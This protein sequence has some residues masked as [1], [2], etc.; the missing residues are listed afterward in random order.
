MIRCASFNVTF[1]EVPSEVCL[2][3]S[4]S[5]CQGR[6]E[7]CHSPYLHHDIGFDLEQELPALLELYHEE[8]TCVC[9]LGEGNDPEALFRCIHL[10]HTSGFKTCLYSGRDLIEEIPLIKKILPLLDYLKVGSYR[11]DLGGLCSRG[12][13][14]QFYAID[15]KN[16]SVK[17]IVHLFWKTKE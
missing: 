17:N 15:Q 2:T 1:Q 4:I 5:N 10:A 8:I 9:F 7:G 12:T 13:N 14:Q 6:C 11:Q 3:L 16:K